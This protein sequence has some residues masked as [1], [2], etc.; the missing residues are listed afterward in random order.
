MAFTESRTPRSTIRSCRC[1]VTRRALRGILVAGLVAI[2]SLGGGTASAALPEDFID[3]PVLDGLVEPVAIEPLPDGRLLVAERRGRILLVD[4]RA[5]GAQA[6]ETLNLSA[7]DTTGER[8]LLGIALHPDH[9]RRDE[10]FLYYNHANRDRARIARFDLERGIADPASEFVIW[11]DPQRA[12]EQQVPDHWGGAFDV[13]PD[14]HLYLAIGDK[15]D[16]PSDSQDLGRSAG[17]I[18]RLA[19]D[20]AGDGAAP[21][22]LNAANA[23]LIPADNPFVDGPG[24]ALDEIWALGLRNPFRGRWAGERFYIS[25][26]GGNIQNGD[27]AS[28]EDLHAVGLADAGVNFGF[29]A[30]EGPRCN[31]GAPA[32]YSPPLFSIVHPDSRALVAGPVYGATRFPASYRGV[33]FLTDYVRGWLRFLRIDDAGA[34]DETTPSG[35]VRFAS[36]GSLGAPVALELGGDGAL[37]YLDIV[38]GSLRRIDYVSDDRPP[39]IESV[40]IAIDDPAAVPLAATLSASARDPE[41]ASLVYEWDLGDGRRLSGAT[42]RALWNEPGRYSVRVRVSDGTYETVSEALDVIVGMPPKVTVSTP[43]DGHV[44]RAGETMSLR[45]RAVDAEGVAVPAEALRWTVHFIHDGHL[46]PAVSDVPGQRCG[47]SSCLDFDVPDSGHD[48]SGDT[49]YRV[50][51]V[52]RTGDGLEGSATIELHPEKIDL[53]VAT[54]LP[55]ATTLTLDDIPRGRAF[56]ID[57][58]VGFR[59]RVEATASAVVEGEVW[60]FSEW[61]DGVVSRVREFVVPDRDTELT[62]LYANLGAAERERE[63][64][65]ALYDFAGLVAGAVPDSAEQ[66]VLSSLRIGV[67]VD[68]GEP[69]TGVRIERPA[70]LVATSDASVDIDADGALAIELWMQPDESMLDRD[71]CLVSLVDER[72]RAWLAIEQ[73]A[74]R[75]EAARYV[76]RRDAD[77]RREESVVGLPG[78]VAAAPTQ[79]VYTRDAVGVER[80]YV[81]GLE[82]AVGASN[83]AAISGLA[84]L[85]VASNENGDMAW[86]G[87]FRLLAL[88]GRSLDADTV[89][90]HYLRG[91]DGSGLANRPPIAR[92]DQATADPGETVMIDV[93]ANDSD[94]DDATTLLPDSVRLTS[95]ALA[96]S[97][98]IRSDGAI[99]YRRDSG[100]RASEV[101]HYTVS[102]TAGGVSNVGRVSVGVR[103]EAG[104][105]GGGAFSILA[106]LTLIVGA[107]RFRAS[108]DL[109][110]EIPPPGNRRAYCPVAI[111]CRRR[112][113]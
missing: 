60:V 41:G 106:L 3:E 40:D 83:A 67:G 81:N 84:A 61:S 78:S 75:S 6:L 37:Y 89:R 15:K 19:I 71:A 29:P 20:G 2:A 22:Q 53:G 107:W 62:A 14:G 79:L 104:G 16:R 46:H 26:V 28:Y 54:D 9:E 100:S 65:Q 80:L 70:A 77:G 1:R 45:G 49:F 31:G 7:V 34:I 98:S 30:C 11:E 8:G 96:G 55:V 58:L 24:G 109:R 59:H 112:S 93:L 57:T 18:L 12:S 33:L 10:L 27:D 36:N 86:I 95:A 5:S 74:G 99:E 42:V 52:A 102:D 97:A 88:Y 21:W 110:G 32:N 17:K 91:A 64:L 76:V 47:A 73:R 69:G 56:T 101:L 35:G 51:L 108:R 68:A 25:E 48:F 103:S 72:G 43:N 63:G 113:G 66:G 4:P 87:T 92:A 38:R 13:G 85:H 105:S 111:R 39:E 44:F 50:A 23:H 82:I 90:R 94:P